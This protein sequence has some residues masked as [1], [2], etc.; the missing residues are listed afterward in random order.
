VVVG[1]SI[2]VFGAIWAQAELRK[3]L[4]AAG[5]RVIEGEVALGR[6]LARFDADARL[7]D[8]N[9]EC[10]LREVVDDLLAEAE[11]NRPGKVAATG[12]VDRWTHGCECTWK[13]R[14]SPNEIS[15]APTKGA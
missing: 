7:D 4:G 10:E 15:T 8:Q 9:P 12:G 3:V 13:R 5:A 14:L 11:L 2:G 1:A 6:A